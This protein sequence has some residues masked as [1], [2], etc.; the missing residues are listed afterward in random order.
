MQLI[1]PVMKRIFRIPQYYFCI[2][3]AVL[4]HRSATCTASWCPKDTKEETAGLRRRRM[5]PLF[6]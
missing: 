1:L 2:E 4:G 3:E 6:D 5:P